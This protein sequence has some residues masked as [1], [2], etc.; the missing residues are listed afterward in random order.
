MGKV[1]ELT[2]EERSVIYTLHKEKYSL[3]QIRVKLEEEYN[4]K[5]SITAITNT[6]KRYDST[7]SHESR[8]RSGRPVLMSDSDRREVYLN[9]L[10]DRR[11]TIPILSEEFNA[12]RSRSASASTIRRSL[13]CWG[14]RG[15][16]AAKKP[17]LRPA[18]IRKR[19]AFA[20]EHV[21][22]SIK[23][24]KRCL[25]SDESKYDLFGTNRRVIVRR[26]EGER[27]KKQCLVATIK[28][29]GGNIMVW[30][31]ISANGVSKLKRIES[32][33]DQKGYHS[34]LQRYAIPAGLRLIG[35]GFVF[36]EDNDPKHASKY[37]RNYL[38]A[39]ES[40]GKIA[41]AFLIQMEF[42]IKFYFHFQGCSKGWFGLLK[43]RT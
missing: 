9:S 14:L 36:Q 12:T 20:K 10:R 42:F 18:N 4:I 28:H 21:K 17:L 19:L 40:K 33:M 5:R 35:Q 30:G 25:F 15:R 41:Y 31:G 24:W 38:A 39:K 34:I 7:G 43:V 23:K 37:C 22:W 29:G 8:E 13:L 26:F 27:F 2:V 32:T 6:I 1:A 11:K 3:R 16:V